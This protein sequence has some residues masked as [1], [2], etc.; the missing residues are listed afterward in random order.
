[1]FLT[2]PKRSP[3]SY[4]FANHQTDSNIRI[5][6]VVTLC[7]ALKIHFSF[8]LSLSFETEID[9]FFVRVLYFTRSI[10]SKKIFHFVVSLKLNLIHSDDHHHYPRVS[11]LSLINVC[12][13]TISLSKFRTHPMMILSSNYLTFC[14]ASRIIRFC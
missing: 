6:S 1:M 3:Q 5:S 13:I 9:A 12:S 8:E 10:E 7:Y 2:T 11:I 14:L 4:S